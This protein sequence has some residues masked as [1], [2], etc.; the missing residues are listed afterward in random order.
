MEN[1]SSDNK[2]DLE[3]TQNR[4]YPVP[5]ECHGK[6]K[7]IIVVANRHRLLMEMTGPSF[8]LTEQ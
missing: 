5:E 7:Y 8:F 3:R 6:G 2:E 1:H 4:E